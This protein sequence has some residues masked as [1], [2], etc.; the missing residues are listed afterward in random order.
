MARSL[1]MPRLSDSMEEATILRWLKGPGDA[2]ARGEPLAEIETDKATVVYEA[3]TDGVIVEIVVPEGGTARLGEAIASV[4]GEAVTSAA[5]SRPEAAPAVS[6]R[7]AGPPPPASAPAPV[8]DRPRA[9][10]VARRRAVELGL[11]LL[12]VAGTGP[13]GRVTVTDVERAAGKAPPRLESRDRGTVE[14][15]ALTP[16]QAT[17]ARRVTESATIPTFTVTVE[18]DVSTIVGLRRGAG[19]VAAPAPSVTDFVVRAAALTLRRFPS[20][21]SSYVDGQ[22]E[23]Y[24]RINVGIAVALDDALLVPT[25]F[26]A[27]RKTLAEIAEESRSLVERARARSLRPE[28]LAH[29]T[30]TVSN[31]GMYGVHSFTAIVSAPQCAI[32]A[33]GGSARRPAEAPDGRV[34]LRDTLFATLSADHRIVYG[35]DGAAFLAHLASLLESPLSLLL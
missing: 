22:V 11:S 13:G 21:N 8:Q 19:D 9:T 5:A 25:L 30:F 14:S 3:D 6:R 18:V 26:D 12:S 4:D 29:A 7:P 27:D 1:T 33:V 28:E 35:A 20:F 31:L 10:P 2:F 24:S 15:V 23:R 32:L 17:V 34:E 16:T